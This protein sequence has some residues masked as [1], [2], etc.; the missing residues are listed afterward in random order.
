MRLVSGI[1][2]GLELL[3]QDSW[4]GSGATGDK[5]P[6]FLSLGGLSGERMARLAG[7][8]AEVGTRPCPGGLRVPALGQTLRAPVPAHEAQRI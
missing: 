3:E 6:G 8:G 5:G 7:A 1:R 2:N 4:L